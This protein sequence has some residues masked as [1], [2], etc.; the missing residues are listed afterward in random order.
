MNKY[1]ATVILGLVRFFSTIVAC[2]ALRRCGRRPLT[3]VSSEFFN[4]F[5]L[6]SIFY[7]FNLFI[8][9]LIGIGCGL[10]ML[11]LGFYLFYKDQCVLN[12][13]VPQMTWIPLVCIFGFIIACT[14]GFLV[15]PW[16][17]IGEVYPLQVR[18]ILFY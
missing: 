8:F 17:M 10:A 2:I 15:V 7:E 14:M 16:V 6:K 5:K 1:L 9:F 18:F 4:F 3:F 12:N 11:G 13:E